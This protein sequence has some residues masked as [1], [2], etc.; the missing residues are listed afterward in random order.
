[1]RTLILR[2]LAPDFISLNETHLS[3]PVIFFE[4]Y[5]W[6]GHNRNIHVKAPRASGGVGIFVKNT[7]F[8]HFKVVIVDKS[9]DGVI[10]LRF[11]HHF[12]KYA[13]VIFSCYLP[14][15]GSSRG[16]DSVSFFNHLLAQLYSINYAAVYLCG[17]LNCRISDKD[18]CISD[19]DGL[20]PRIALD[21][22][23]NNHGE[24]LLDFLKDSKCCILNGRLC[25][26]KDNFT[27]ISSKGK[28]VVDYIITAHDCIST[29]NEFEVITALQLCDNIGA[30]CIDLIGDRCR[31][32]DHS[33]LSL[34]FSVEPLLYFDECAS[35][36]LINQSK[37]LRKFPPTFLSSD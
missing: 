19:I 4:G 22:V 35:R 36:P 17:D 28:A 27:S 1:M 3:S 26:S 11:E 29:C 15:E 24:S 12:T 31:L 6:F 2:S 21:A 10:G 25:P 30:E 7:V 18:D 32:P 23:M 16:R 34:K 13:F 20:V 14:P 9:I 33:L 37:I 8:E 5:T